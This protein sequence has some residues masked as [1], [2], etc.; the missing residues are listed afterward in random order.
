MN[1]EQKIEMYKNFV[2]WYRSVD[3]GHDKDDV[4][5]RNDVIHTLYDD[6][7]IQ[8]SNANTL[9]SL[10]L[11]S[12][13]DIDIGW[14]QEAFREVDE[15]FPS[16]I[17]S[18][19]AELQTLGGISL[20]RE[21]EYKGEESAILAARFISAYFDGRREIYCKTVPV[22]DLA[23][24]AIDA[25]SSDA[26]SRQ[27]YKQPSLELD[28]QILKQPLEALTNQPDTIQN[29]G[30]AVVQLLKQQNDTIKSLGE[31]LSQANQ[32]LRVQDEELNLLWWIYNERSERLAMQIKEL[33]APVRGIVC[34]IEISSL[35][36]QPVEPNNLSSFIHRAL[37]SEASEHTIK[38]YVESMDKP[39]N[40][41]SGKTC[42]LVSPILYAL[43][44]Y[45]DT[46]KDAWIMKWE[47]ETELSA[48]ENVDVHSLTQQIC[49]ECLAMEHYE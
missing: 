6:G 40:I 7:K 2:D 33:E 15:H 30:K 37:G 9:L 43:S 16:D 18:N 4:K 45:E 20:A 41:Y 46:G 5:L 19:P 27:D 32:L 10:I 14:Y 44:L 28:T 13:Q 3:L 47:R 49:R 36:T 31:S 1:E 42:S 12:K 26:R 25:F 38:E 22:L 23:N 48:D 34:G 8:G 11:S 24:K 17:K 21:F 29:F 39:S 35:I